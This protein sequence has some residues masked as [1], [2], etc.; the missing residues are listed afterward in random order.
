MCINIIVFNKLINLCVMIKRIKN[1][2][3]KMKREIEEQ[4]KRRKKRM[5]NKLDKL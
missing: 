5:T 1:K 2:N 4:E 3:K